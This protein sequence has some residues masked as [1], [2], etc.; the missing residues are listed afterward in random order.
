MVVDARSPVLS[1]VCDDAPVFRND[2]LSRDER[3]AAVAWASVSIGDD[4]AELDERVPPVATVKDEAAEPFEPSLVEV[5]LCILVLFAVC[6][7]ELE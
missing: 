5:V 7:D 1:E 3:D 4:I 2:M 6:I